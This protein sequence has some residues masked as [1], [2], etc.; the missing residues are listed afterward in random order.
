MPNREG[1]QLMAPRRSR[2]RGA[3]N[4][5]LLPRIGR[6]LPLLLHPLVRITPPPAGVTLERDVEVRVR[7]GTVLRANVFRPEA[8][9]PYPVIVSAHPYGKDNLP[10]PRGRGRNGRP[11][12]GVPIQYRMLSP[13]AMVE[14]SAWTGWEAPD[15]G[16]WVPRGYV[17]VNVDLRGWGKSDGVGELFSAQEGRDYHDI[18]EWAAA[19]PWSNGRVGT[20]GVSYLAIAQWRMAAE[21]PPHLACICPW[22]GFTDAYRDLFRP[23]G[24]REDGFSIVWALL[25]KRQRRSPVDFRSQV[26]RRELRDVWYAARDPR[27]E[28]IEAPALV[29]ASFSDHNLHS[30]GSFD[31]YR[32]IRSREKWLY[33]HRGPK[34]AAYYSPEALEVQA[35][36]FDHFCKAEGGPQLPAEPVRVEIRSDR[37]TVS[38]VREVAAWPP[39]GTFFQPLYFDDSGQLSPRAPEGA[40]IVEFA[41]RSGS[42]R[43]VHRFRETTDVVGPMWCHLAV[44]VRGARDALLFLAVRK[45]RHGRVV[46][47]EG[48]YGFDDAAVALGWLRVSHRAPSTFDRMSGLPVQ[49]H[50]RHLPVRDGE[51]MWLDIELRASATRFDAGDELRLDIQGR[52]FFSRLPVLGQF[53]A[54]WMPNCVALKMPGRKGLRR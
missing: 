51:L 35:R 12:Y 28:E 5:A 10:A 2:R 50:D 32:R 11:R 9:G 29:C 53:P 3:S 16:F 43:F 25:L 30:R 52:W 41:L 45:L 33:T 20:N 1:C 44:E 17:V 36:F 19:Q 22:E 39:P 7:D 27:L 54:D 47:F 23:G 6:R 14:H 18:V 38:E 48:S 26:R 15:P 4:P 31:A 42:A 24:I 34:W 37:R 40:G 8:P 49:A 21:R 46:G 13:S